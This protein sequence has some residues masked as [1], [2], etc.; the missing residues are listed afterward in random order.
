MPSIIFSNQINIKEGISCQYPYWILR[1]NRA[2]K[3]F[4]LR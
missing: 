1:K 2:T 4:V 3:L